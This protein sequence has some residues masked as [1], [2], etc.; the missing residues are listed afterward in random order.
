MGT[1]KGLLRHPTRG[2]T[3]LEAQVKALADAGA[4]AV[5]V[6]LGHALEDHERSIP[7]VAT[8]AGGPF[9][10]GGAEVHVIVNP[11]PD[12]GPFSSLVLAVL[13]AR[14]VDPGAPGFAVLPV[15]VP[16]P[17]ATTWDALRTAF[18][19]R[20]DAVHVVTPDLAGRGGHPVLVDRAFADGLVVRSTSSVPQ[21]LD[22][23]IADA[24]ESA[25]LRVPVRDVRVVANLNT[26][27]DFARWAGDASSSDPVAVPARGRSKLDGF[28]EE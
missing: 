19:E 5:T 16:C 8:R 27:D 20:A 6:V 22:H 15:D 4:R 14:S 23:A 28:D 18:A 9:R 10:E 17:E 24:G 25:R 26:P 13:R 1:P 21:R 2:T 11:D 3:F 12:R 7:F